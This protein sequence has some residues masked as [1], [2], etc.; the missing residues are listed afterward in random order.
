[1][2]LAYQGTMLAD[3]LAEKRRCIPNFKRSGPPANATLPEVSGGKSYLKLPEQIIHGKS[4]PADTLLSRDV[5]HFTEECV[6]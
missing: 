1:V 3:L 4:L 2:A 5:N 6:D